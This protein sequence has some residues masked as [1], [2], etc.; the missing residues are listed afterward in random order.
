MLAASCNLPYLT[1]GSIIV[2]YLLDNPS[3]VY[4]A[5]KNYNTVEHY[6]VDVEYDQHQKAVYRLKTTSPVDVTITRPNS[7]YLSFPRE[8][9][10]KLSY[11]NEHDLKLSLLARS[12]N[13][14]KSEMAALILHYALDSAQIVLYFQE[15]YNIHKHYWVTPLEENGVVNYMLAP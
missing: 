1:L 7:K 10:M 6:L 14:K 8:R 5:Q 4:T 15:R 12:C 3:F 2:C 13:L 11:S 9:R